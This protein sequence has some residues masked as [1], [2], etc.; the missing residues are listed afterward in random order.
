[1][2][3]IFYGVMTLVANNSFRALLTSLGIGIA[4]GAIFYDL[5]SN[6]INSVISSASAVPF[7]SLL[8]IFGIDS[9]L[10]IIFGAILTRV[11]IEA[12]NISLRK[13]P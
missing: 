7:I 11:S 1:M 8:G 3:K 10:S 9:G 5:V 12:S 4:T 6:Y 2:W 13:R